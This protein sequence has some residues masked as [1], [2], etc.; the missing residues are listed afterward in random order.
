MTLFV[1]IYEGILTEKLSFDFTPQSVHISYED[2]NK[3]SEWI[4]L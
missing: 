3:D 4:L 1:L 2:E